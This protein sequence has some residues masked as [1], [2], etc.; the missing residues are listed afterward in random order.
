MCTS[1]SSNKTLNLAK[2]CFHCAVIA[3]VAQWMSM[4]FEIE[5]LDRK[6]RATGIRLFADQLESLKRLRIHKHRGRC[7]IADLIRQAIDEFIER[8]SSGEGIKR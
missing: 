6:T 1:T 4:D 3:L 5:D 2:F 8:E 7:S